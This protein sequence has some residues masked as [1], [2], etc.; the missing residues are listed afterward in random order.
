MNSHYKI[1]EA[2]SSD[3]KALI[4][5]IA[6]VFDEYD[7]VFDA[8]EEIPD[9]V[10]YDQFYENDS[11]LPV[12]KVATTMD[13]KVVACA[14][15]K[16]DNRGVYLSR[17]YVAKSHRRQGLAQN[18]INDLMDSANAQDIH[19]VHLWT[20]TLFHDAHKLYERLEF[21]YTGHVRPLNDANGCYEYHYERLL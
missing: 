8:E 6:Q 5:L 18:L 3:S 20:D 1:R 16:P 12:L 19:Y 9:I 15:L 13:D 2:K 17:I 11:V 14:G 7:W 21:V 4:E 10:H